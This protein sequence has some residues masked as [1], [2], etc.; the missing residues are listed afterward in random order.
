M[1][2]YNSRLIEANKVLGLIP[3]TTLASCD[4][5]HFSDAITASRLIASDISV[6]DVFDFGSGNGFPGLVLGILFPK[7]SVVLVEIDKRKCDFLSG[8]I[9]ELGLNNVRVLNSNVGDLPQGSV[10]L[11]IARGFGPITKC[12]LLT[13]TLFKKGGKFYHLKG[14]EWPREIAEIPS[15]LCSHWTPSLLGEFKL[16]LGSGKLGVVVT[17]KI[18]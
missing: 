8:L 13:R 12:L 11:A 2:K 4:L 3:I 10:E 17:Q 16:P 1:S 14:D 6:G 15:Q 5:I 9:K 7:I 18:S